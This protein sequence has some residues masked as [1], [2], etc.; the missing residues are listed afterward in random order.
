MAVFILIFVLSLQEEFQLG[1]FRNSKNQSLFADRVSFLALIL[2][3][4]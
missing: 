2:I 1:L 4:R 3:L